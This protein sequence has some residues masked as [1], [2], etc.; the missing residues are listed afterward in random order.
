VHCHQAITSR[1]PGEF[2]ATIVPIRQNDAAA[3]TSVLRDAVLER[4]F[5]HVGSVL[6][7]QIEDVATRV[8]DGRELVDQAHSRGPVP[9]V[10]A[11]AWAAWAVSLGSEVP[12]VY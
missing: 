4:K 1:I 8:V 11:A 9:A 2:P 5:R 6:M 3:A 7:D 10:K 12:L